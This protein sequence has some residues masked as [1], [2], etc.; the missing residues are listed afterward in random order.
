[1]S[2]D[3][4]LEEKCPKCDCYLVQKVTKKNIIKHCSNESCD[5][6]QIL[7]LTT[8]INND[9]ENEVGENQD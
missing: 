9:G 6:T 8:E 1:M 7:P 3:M 5:Y 2:W 4:P